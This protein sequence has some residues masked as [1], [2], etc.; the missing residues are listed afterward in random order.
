M[1]PAYAEMTN[2]P[3][4]VA[5]SP[6]ANFAEL[7]GFAQIPGH[8]RDLTQGTPDSATGRLVRQW[9]HWRHFA[10]MPNLS[11]YIWPPACLLSPGDKLNDIGRGTL[12]P[13]RK[14]L[15]SPRTANQGR[16]VW[17]NCYH[18]YPAHAEFG[19][20]KESGFGRENHKMMLEHYQQTKNLLVSYSPQKPGFF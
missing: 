14:P 10:V 13:R 6:N 3:A 16:R 15:L 8:L 5:A 1:S 7:S 2:N 9:K 19:G 20:Y 12:E 4:D 18:L 17:V 11:G